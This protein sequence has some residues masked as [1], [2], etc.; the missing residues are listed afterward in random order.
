[1][2]KCATQIEIRR[3]VGKI[4]C[5]VVVAVSLAWRSRWECK[6]IN[7]TNNFREISRVNDYLVV[8]IVV[9][10]GT[11]RWV[12][13]CGACYWVDKVLGNNNIVTHSCL[14][15]SMCPTT[16]ITAWAEAAYI[17][18]IVGQ[19]FQTIDNNAIG[20]CTQSSTCTKG[21]TWLTIF[22]FIGCGVG[23]SIPCKCQ[24]VCTL[25]IVGV[26][27]Q[28]GNHTCGRDTAHIEFKARVCNGTVRL[29][30][31]CQ[32]S[33]GGCCRYGS[34][35]GEAGAGKSNKLCACGAHTIVDI[36][37]VVRVTFDIGSTIDAYQVVGCVGH[38][39]NI[40]VLTH[41]VVAGR[42]TV[43]IDSTTAHIYSV[44][45]VGTHNPYAWTCGTNHSPHGGV[46][47][48]AVIAYIEIVVSTRCETCHSIRMSCYSHCGTLH[49]VGERCSRIADN[50]AVVG[51]IVATPVKCNSTIGA[52]ENMQ[53]ANRCTGG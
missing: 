8:T 7:V 47:S 16:G 11:H 17:N 46:A 45:H 10:A 6:S 48:T 25:S 14:E 40:A 31:D 52:A 34:A 22:N 33:A 39:D 21:K 49:W 32:S 2:D 36:K 30:I 29:E 18:L 38:K 12:G 13:W 24:W 35:A 53:V 42:T 3:N 27:S 20:R 19:S 1:M 5:H 50:P 43:V 9:E 37:V 23:D 4:D 28:H 15:Y 44:G 51:A 26:T 41:W